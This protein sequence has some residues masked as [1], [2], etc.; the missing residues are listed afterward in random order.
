MLKKSNPKIKDHVI[1]EV[2]APWGCDSCDLYKEDEC[3]LG[4]V[5][6]KL[7]PSLD[8]VYKKNEGCIQIVCKDYYTED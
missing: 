3:M 6:G 7:V 2:T 1:I 8:I 4:A 5:P